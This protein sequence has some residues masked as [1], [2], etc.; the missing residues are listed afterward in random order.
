[1]RF[2]I[3]FG[4]KFEFFTSVSFL[5]RY[6]GQAGWIYYNIPLL[7]LAFFKLTLACIAFSMESIAKL[8]RTEL[9]RSLRGSKVDRSTP[10]S[11]AGSGGLLFISA[12]WVLLLEKNR[13]WSWH[14]YLRVCMLWLCVYGTWGLS[15]AVTS[16]RHACTV[17]ITK[18]KQFF[19]KPSNR[20]R[21]WDIELKRNSPIETSSFTWELI[22][23]LLPLWTSLL[24]DS[25]KPLSAVNAR[26][27]YKIKSVSVTFFRTKSS[28]VCLFAFQSVLFCDQ[29]S[30]WIFMSILKLNFLTS[31]DEILISWKTDNST[32]SCCLCSIVFHPRNLNF[33]QVLVLKKQYNMVIICSGL[34]VISICQTRRQLL[35]VNSPCNLRDTWT[36]KEV[37]HGR[38]RVMC[39]SVNLMLHTHRQKKTKT[40]NIVHF[41]KLFKWSVSHFDLWTWRTH[42]ECCTDPQYMVFT[43]PLGSQVHRGYVCK[44]SRSS[45]LA[46]LRCTFYLPIQ[47][48]L[49]PVIEYMFGKENFELVWHLM[50]IFFYFSCIK[51]NCVHATATTTTLTFSLKEAVSLLGCVCIVRVFPGAVPWCFRFSSLQWIRW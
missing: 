38:L 15:C 46:V 37:L 42:M 4:K 13:A 16:P 39:H 11:D 47:K 3:H 33:M 45:R 48:C 14:L 19:P 12:G 36:I 23:H 24:F 18:R 40:L 44:G 41:L 34:P 26:F 17:R 21:C 20:M 5:V 22:C 51:M 31:N 32:W 1:M 7:A 6:Y 27:I 2:H 50:W 49:F 8:C 25:L 30:W 29:Y 43:H 10:A 35:S 28:I 9:A